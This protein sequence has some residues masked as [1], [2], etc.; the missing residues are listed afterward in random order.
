[1]PGGP[2]T[3]RAGIQRPLLVQALARRG[4]GVSLSVSSSSHRTVWAWPLFLTPSITPPDFQNSAPA[5]KLY[6]S[7]A[8]S[9]KA[10][11]R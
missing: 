7:C 2:P 11:C 5:R 6:P 9:R 4:P 8:Q 3:L 10:A 1:M